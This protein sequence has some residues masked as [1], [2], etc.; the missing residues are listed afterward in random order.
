MKPLDSVVTI[1]S[2]EISVAPPLVTQVGNR[3][4]FESST[5]VHHPSAPALDEVMC[6]A[7]AKRERK[8]QVWER[9]KDVQERYE[10][11]TKINRYSRY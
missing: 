3:N 1:P 9:Q 4:I 10:R 6:A 7:E 2:D 11:N 8:Q 5:K